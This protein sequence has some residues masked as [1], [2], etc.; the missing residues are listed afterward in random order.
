MIN[1][2]SI[3]CGGVPLLKTSK[4]KK[5]MLCYSSSINMKTKLAYHDDNDLSLN[6]LVIE[7]MK[8]IK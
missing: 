1:L 2:S 4:R 6:T 7:N 3:M 8:L 5:V